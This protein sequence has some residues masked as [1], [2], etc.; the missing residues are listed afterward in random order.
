[1]EH[2]EVFAQPDQRVRA[3]HRPHG[4]GTLVHLQVLTHWPAQA[5]DWNGGS[6]GKTSTSV[7]VLIQLI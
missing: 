6:A 5:E 4:G 7:N 3:E 1:M 2:Q